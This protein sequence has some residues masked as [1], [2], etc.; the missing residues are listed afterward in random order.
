VAGTG[1]SDTAGIW[2]A[3]TPANAFHRRLTLALMA[4]LFLAFLMA[5][6]FANVSFPSSNGFIPYIQGTMFVAELI[7]AALLFTKFSI[8]RSNALLIL[9]NGYLFCAVIIIAHTLTFP[10][11]FAPGGLLGA[12]FQTAGWLHVVWHLVFPASVIAYAWMRNTECSNDT[13]Y[14]LGRAQKAAIFSNIAI[15]TGSVIALTCGIIAADKYLPS[16][17]LDNRAFASLAIYTGW[18]TAATCV[19]AIF[20]LWKG[21]QSV[22][23]GWVMVAIFATLLEMIMLSFIRERFTIGW[24]CVRFFGVTTSTIVLIALLTETA[25]LYA[26]LAVALRTLERDRDNKLINVQA[27]VAAIAHEVRQPLTGIAAGGGAARRFLERNPPDVVRARVSLERVVDATHHVSQVFDGIR[28][29]FGK[30]GEG[31]GLVDLNKI[32]LDVMQSMRV[33]FRAHLVAIQTDLTAELPLVTGHEGQLRELVTN[34]FQNAFEAMRE[35]RDRT[36]LLKVSTALHNRTEVVFTAEDT[37]PGIEPERLASIFGAF[38]TTK[39][40][41]TGLGLAICR[42]IVE[43]HGGQLT[44]SSDGVSGARFQFVLPLVEPMKKAVASAA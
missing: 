34:L 32:V 21:E 10:G 37:G 44:A 8:L 33:E 23:N 22:L 30:G 29:L 7:T 36:R 6:S 35:T 19:V 1:R 28:A 41:G 27:V 38:V 20:S 43:H 42:M 39:A 18:F 31:Q 5:A 14:A 4:A 9:A 12:S 24:Y 13:P 40:Q 26:R 16:L 17:F 15:V 3:T 25:T 11:A 2:L